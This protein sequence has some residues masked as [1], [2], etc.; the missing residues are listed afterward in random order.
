MI[1]RYKQREV[2]LFDYAQRMG[3][4]T[5]IERRPKFID[6]Y[7]DSKILVSEE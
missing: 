4:E 6:M 1:Q 3:T 2:R 7:K 5:V